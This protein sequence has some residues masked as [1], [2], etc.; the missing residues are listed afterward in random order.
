M[1]G[2]WAAEFPAEM[3][4]YH[5]DIRAELQKHMCDEKHATFK[6]VP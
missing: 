4:E 6:K 2:L 5:G 3:G 1:R